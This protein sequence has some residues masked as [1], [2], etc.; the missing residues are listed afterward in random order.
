MDQSD[1]PFEERGVRT[2]PD[3]HET[4]VFTAQTH[5]AGGA[6][7]TPGEA[8]EFQKV[9]AADVTIHPEPS[10]LPRWV[11]AMVERKVPADVF[12]R[13]VADRTGRAPSRD[14][15]LLALTLANE[16]A[17]MEGGGAAIE[18]H[19]TPELLDRVSGRAERAK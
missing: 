18:R 2:P 15:Q 14:N 13:A 9:A 7:R 5:E 6:R 17:R 19:L 16:I 3:R 10:E 12:A 11:R 4:T 8:R 1:Y